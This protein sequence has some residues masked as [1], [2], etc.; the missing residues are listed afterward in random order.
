M[1]RRKIGGRRSEPRPV[2]RIVGPQGIQGEPCKCPFSPNEVK[3]LRLMLVERSKG[4]GDL[5]QG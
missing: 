1:K 4:N 5:G 2:S 3:E